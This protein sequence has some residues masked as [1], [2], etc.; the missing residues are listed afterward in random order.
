MNGLKIAINMNKEVKENRTSL[1]SDNL[2]LHYKYDKHF[3]VR[4]AN[5]LREE[6][7]L[8]IETLKIAQFGNIMSIARSFNYGANSSLHL[9]YSDSYDELHNVI[10]YANIKKSE[11]VVIKKVTCY[12]D[13]SLYILDH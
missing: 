5:T 1:N 11:N 4:L 6:Y 2:T 12:V 10:I 9:V 3:E 8:D 13:N 7:D